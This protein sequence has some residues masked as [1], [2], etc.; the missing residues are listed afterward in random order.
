MKGIVIMLDYLEKILNGI[1]GF[2]PTLLLAIVIYIVGVFVNKAIL[3]LFAKGT[4]RS[5]MDQTV[6]KF[7]SSVIKIIIT[8][9]VLII[10]LTV[11]GIPMTSIITVLG[12]AGVAVGL[13]LKDSLA[14][15]A[16]GVILLINQNIKVGN[17]VEIGAYSGT[18]EEI[19][20]L[21]TKL[22]TPDNKDIF[23]PNGVVA[24]SAITNYSSEGSRR[25]DLLFGIS[26]DNDHRKAVD[27]I[28]K[29]VENHPLI[30]KDTPPFVRLSGLAE[31]SLNITVR[32]WAKS[33]DYWTVYFDLIEQVKE[34][35]DEENIVIPYN[36]L[37][38]HID[39]TNFLLK[40]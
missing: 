12:T 11:L 7:L 33:E 38:V 31:S 1:V 37:D 23:I 15:V 9:L 27:A 8:A 30:L 26:Y 19:S 35:F 2:L 36:Q 14:N 20:I 5:R 4:E 3:K 24:T 16:G 29:V 40:A 22:S 18:V 6:R 17:Y 28:N 13:A 39:N 25:V 34:K 10:V 21:F 32:V